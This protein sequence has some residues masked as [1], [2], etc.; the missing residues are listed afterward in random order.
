MI[1]NCEANPYFI[2]IAAGGDGAVVQYWY[3]GWDPVL[4]T[5]IVSHQGTDTSKMYA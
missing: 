3:V 2:P 5:I 1:A 4:Q